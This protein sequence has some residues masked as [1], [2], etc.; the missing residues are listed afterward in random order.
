MKK[1]VLVLVVVLVLSGIFAVAAFTSV[2]MDREVTAT[3]RSDTN[4]DVAVFFQPGPNYLTVFTEADGVVTI[5]LG[6]VFTGGFNPAALFVVGE[7][8]DGTGDATDSDINGAVFGITNNS[9]VSSIEVSMAEGANIELLGNSVAGGTAVIPFGETEWFHF[10]FSTYVI[11][12]GGTVD[13]LL[14]IR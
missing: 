1:L 14:E 9:N 6:N 13:G 2:T 3:V 4:A 12:P 8:Y 5:D 11:A 7:E 10:S